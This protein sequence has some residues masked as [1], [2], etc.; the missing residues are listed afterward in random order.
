MSAVPA[1]R[2]PTPLADVQRHQIEDLT[3]MGVRNL[4]LF[5]TALTAPS[6]I[7]KDRIIA[8]SFDR[9]EYLG[10]AAVSLAFRNWV[11]ARYT[12][13]VSMLA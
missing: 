10:D 5:R 13:L 8:A 2:S 1:G 6:A 11:Y 4:E 3:Q 12:H 9:L 7:S